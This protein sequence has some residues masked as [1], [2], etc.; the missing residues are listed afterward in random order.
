MAIE[1]STP[2]PSTSTD[3][4]SLP[5]HHSISSVHAVSIYLGPL[6]SFSTQPWHAEWQSLSP[7]ESSVSI[8]KLGFPQKL[9][10]YSFFRLG[11]YLGLCGSLGTEYELPV[12]TPEVRSTPYMVT[13][14]WDSDRVLRSTEYGIRSIGRY[15]SALA[16]LRPGFQGWVD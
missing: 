7:P 8:H 1:H 15:H 3:I 2:F 12:I 16:K 11:V 9:G 5:T 4:Y 14:D 13:G 10:F 6:L